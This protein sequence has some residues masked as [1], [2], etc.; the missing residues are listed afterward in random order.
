[1]P[2][3]SSKLATT[4]AT[5]SDAIQQA[6]RKDALTAQQELEAEKLKN[7]EQQ[8]KNDFITAE[9]E[10][11]KAMTAQLKARLQERHDGI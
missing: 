4:F 6:N 10:R 9:L 11:E 8:R 1:M 7:L 2:A 5:L 3:E